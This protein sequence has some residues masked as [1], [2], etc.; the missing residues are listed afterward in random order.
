MTNDNNVEVIELENEVTLKKPITFNNQEYRTLKLDLDK[1]TGQDIEDAEL[2]YTVRNP[3]LSAQTP[4]K[5]LSKGFQAIVAAKAAGLP[6]DVIKSMS[7]SDYGKVTR[8]VQ[9]FLLKGD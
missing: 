7:A 1:L 6:V 2:Q 4:M 8:M 3:D 5:D 9:V